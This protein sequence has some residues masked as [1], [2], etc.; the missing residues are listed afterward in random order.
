[1]IRMMMVI[2]W[3]RQR[4]RWWWCRC[5]CWWWWWRWWSWSC[6]DHDDQARSTAMRLG[7]FQS[8]A[9][10]RV[11]KRG[12]YLWHLFWHFLWHGHCRTSTASARSQWTPRSG[13]RG[14]GPAVPA[15]TWSW[16]GKRQRRRAR[17]RRKEEGASNS[18]FKETLAWQ[19]GKNGFEI[20]GNACIPLSL[21]F[22]DSPAKF[23]WNSFEFVKMKTKHS[24][25]VSF[26]NSKISEP[27]T[28][29]RSRH[30]LREDV[31]LLSEGR[32]WLDSIWQHDC[33]PILAVTPGGVTRCQCL[34]LGPTSSYSRKLVGKRD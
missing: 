4:R 27:C 26:Q 21:D 28:G 34:N 31:R 15:E 23:R 20:R 13:A 32:T 1:M 16:Q 9:F 17:R 3:W 7:T 2:F 25:L 19:V 11:P 10:Q 14:W 6:H 5:C 22:G 33:L 12:P 29:W 8:D 24:W 18:R 30:V